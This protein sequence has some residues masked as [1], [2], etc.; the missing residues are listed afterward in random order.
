M[1]QGRVKEAEAIVREAASKNKVQAPPVIFK[2]SEV[3][4]IHCY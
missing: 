1:T 2:E 4:F 3:R